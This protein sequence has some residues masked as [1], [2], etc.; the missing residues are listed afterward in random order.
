MTQ[1]SIRQLR[2]RQRRKRKLRALRRKLNE[3]TDVQERRRL[4][5]KIRRTSPR[6]PVPER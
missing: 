3:T 6:A 4:I 2:R 5:A 1:T